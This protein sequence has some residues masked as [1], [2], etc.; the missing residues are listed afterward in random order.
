MEARGKHL[1]MEDW[2]H[3]KAEENAYNEILTFLMTILGV[4]LLKRAPEASSVHATS[5]HHFDFWV[6]IAYGSDCPVDRVSPLLGIYVAVT[7]E[8]FRGTNNT[9]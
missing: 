7:R 5:H 1:S 3:R 4:N 9:E 2:L 6:I 8:I